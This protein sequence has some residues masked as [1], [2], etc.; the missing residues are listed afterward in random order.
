MHT[1]EDVMAGDAQHLSA[2]PVAEEPKRTAE[3]FKSTRTF[4]RVT[5]RAGPEQTHSGFMC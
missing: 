2:T 3:E 5:R 4:P 1:W